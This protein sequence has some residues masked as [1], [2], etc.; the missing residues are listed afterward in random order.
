MYLRTS[1][2]ISQY[3]MLQRDRWKNLPIRHSFIPESYLML[4][5]SRIMFDEFIPKN[6]PCYAVGSHKSLRCFLQAFRKPDPR[7]RLAA[8]VLALPKGRLLDLQFLFHASPA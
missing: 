3:N 2:F 6:L 1:L 8:N 4:S 5:C 7:I